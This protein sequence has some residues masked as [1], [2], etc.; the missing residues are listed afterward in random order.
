[1]Q[2]EITNRARE[3]L[4]KLLEEEPGKSVRLF[5]EGEVYRVADTAG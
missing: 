3:A 2:I 5:V 4:T 1:M